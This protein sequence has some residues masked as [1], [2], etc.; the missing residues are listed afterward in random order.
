MMHIQ[1]DKR[2]GDKRARFYGSE[3]LLALQYLHQNNIV[4]RYVPPPSLLALLNDGMQLSVLST[5]PNTA[6]VTCHFL[7]SS[8]LKLD[9]ILLTADGH[10]KIADYGLCKENMPFG[11]ST[12]T[13]CG[14]PEFMA[15]EIL[16]EQPYDRAVDWWAYGVLMY[17]MLLGRAPFSGEEEDDIYDSILEDEPFYP[18]GFGRHEQALLQ[19][20]LVKVPNLRLGAGPTDAEEIKAHAYFRGVN[21]DD[22]YHKRIPPPFVP[23]ISSATD[24]SNFDSE[25]TSEI[26]GETPSDY[27]L[28]DVEQDLFNNFSYVSPWIQ[29]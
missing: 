19:S 10:I 13:I 26:P 14:T 17:E 25:F 20:L 1:R 11:A 18:T 16:E 7:L 21:F 15:P 12:R 28:K 27:R 24:V 9:N 8:D 6:F 5:L 22:I 2:F 3:V 4:Y 23:K 29:P